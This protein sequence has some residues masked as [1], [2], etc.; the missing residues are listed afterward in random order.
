MN[1]APARVI[2]II[3]HGGKPP[4]KP[5]TGPPFGI[6]GSG[7]PNEHSLIPKGWQ[8]AGALTSLFAPSAG[9]MRSGLLEPTQ[10]IA[11]DY[12]S[13]DKNA[14]H[15]THETI[16]PLSKRISV[17]IETPYEEGNEDELGATVSEEQSGVTLICWEHKAIYT[18]ATNIKPL[19]AGTQIPEWPGE[20]FDVV[21]SFAYD[22]ANSE[23][24]SSQIPQMLLH[25]DIAAPIG[26]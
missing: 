10:L 23:Y 25:N 16:H 3:R 14:I 17:G 11:P 7:S 9:P 2:F 13:A 20:R 6:D 15:R 22:G 19:A 1:H 5:D 26:G 4:D 8:R 12:G 21:F 24:V 18:I